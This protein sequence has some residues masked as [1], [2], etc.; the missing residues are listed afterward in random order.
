MYTI[1]KYTKQD[2]NSTCLDPII[3]SNSENK[4]MGKLI[5]S[6]APFTSQIKDLY[7]NLRHQRFCYSQYQ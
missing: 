7:F 6:L 2:K 3:N 5:L 4:N 1:L